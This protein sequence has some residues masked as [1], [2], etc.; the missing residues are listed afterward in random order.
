MRGYTIR[1]MENR[2]P[3]LV[4]LPPKVLERIDAY[5]KSQPAPPT[6]TAVIEAAIGEF[7]DAHMKGGRK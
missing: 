4:K 2:K 5:C 3:V 7:L 6:R 1:D